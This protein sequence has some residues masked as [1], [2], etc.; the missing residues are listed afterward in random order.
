MKKAEFQKK[1]D[2]IK[3]R[4]IEYL[5]LKQKMID[6]NLLKLE[7]VFLTNT[8]Y[9]LEL[10]VLLAL[11]LINVPN[12]LM[13]VPSSVTLKKTNFYN[14]ITNTNQTLLCTN[15]EKLWLNLPLVLLNVP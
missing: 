8:K 5:D 14:L 9:M 10:N 2:L 1:L 12:L 3:Q 15:L 11:T 6:E 4:K 13:V 7:M